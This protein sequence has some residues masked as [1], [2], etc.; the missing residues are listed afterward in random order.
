VESL[1]LK[2]EDTASAIGTPTSATLEIEDDDDPPVVEFNASTYAVS[3]DEGAAPIT[4]TLQ[5]LSA[6]TATVAVSTSA[7]SATPGA[8]YVAVQSMPVFP[9]GVTG[10]VVAV[11]IMDDGSDEDD[12]TV[13]LT[14]ADTLDATVG[15]H[16]PA[17]LTI[18]GGGYEVF[19]PLT[20]RG[21]P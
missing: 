17:I 11:T 10:Q 4:V 13:V 1:E 3:E 12:E 21:S 6:V 19:L 15:G 16:N 18:T 20:L 7:G 2:L 5:G 14:L 8:D 9:P